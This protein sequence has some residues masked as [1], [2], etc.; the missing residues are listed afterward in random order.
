MIFFGTY[1]RDLHK[2]V[3]FFIAYSLN[4]VIVK[5]NILSIK[6]IICY[7]FFSIFASLA[8]S[9]PSA[10]CLDLLIDENICIDDV[11]LLNPA[12]YVIS[13]CELIP[14][15]T[16][17]VCMIYYY[18]HIRV[19]LRE[20]ANKSGLIIEGLWEIIM[21]RCGRFFRYCFNIN[22]LCFAL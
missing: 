20:E 11:D 4:Q 21:L 15:V 17:F 14:D 6:R 18:I 1:F 22:F 10:L 13:L 8:R 3:I 12:Y 16:I 9:I 5:E 7:L 2:F 19:S